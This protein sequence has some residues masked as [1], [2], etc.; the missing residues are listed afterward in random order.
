MVVLCVCYCVIIVSSW[1]RSRLSLL[2]IRRLNRPHSVMKRIINKRRQKKHN[3]KRHDVFMKRTI[4]N[5]NKM[6]STTRIQITSYS[7][8]FETKSLRDFPAAGAA[9]AELLLSL[10]AFSARGG[11]SAGALPC[12]AEHAAA[13]E[14]LPQLLAPR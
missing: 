14:L 8:K 1:F 2:T 9:Y 10:R 3:I 11:H 13:R 5:N 4:E 12:R 6:T 7:L